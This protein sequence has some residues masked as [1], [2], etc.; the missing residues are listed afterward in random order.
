[1]V[2]TVVLVFVR[3]IVC[4]KNTTRNLTCGIG[5]SLYRNGVKTSFGNFGIAIIT[6]GRLYSMFSY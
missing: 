2:L 4:P 1:L 6:L 5:M 3:T